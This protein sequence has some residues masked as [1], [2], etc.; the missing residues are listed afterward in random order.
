[1]S[2]I[3]GLPREALDRARRSRDPRFDGKFFVAVLSTGIY[4]RSTCPVRLS[5]AIRYYATAAAA[6][7]AGFRPCL[8]C[9][10]EAAPGSPAWAGTSAVVR[11]ALR[12]IQ[13]GALDTGSVEELAAHVGLGVRHLSRLM[14]GQVGASPLAIAQTRR[15]H[16][17]KQLLNDT[18]IPMTEIA[19]AAGFRSVRRFNEAVKAAYK[20]SPSEIRRRPRTRSGDASEEITLQLSY[21]PPYDW[22]HM[23]TF[24]ARRAIPS[25]ERVDAQSYARTVRT[26]TGHARIEI[27]PC[28]KEHA[29]EMR[30]RGAAPADLFEL[31]SAA[32]RVFD[33]SADPH[34]IASAF[35]DDSILSTL[36]AQRPGLRI[37]GVFDPFECAVRAILSQ[38][39]SID[40]GRDFTARLVARAGQS[41]DPA[42][43]GL[44]RLFPTPEIIADLDLGNVGLSTARIAAIRALARAMCDGAIRFNASAEDIIRALTQLPGVGA[45]T[46]QYVALHGL[47]DPDAFLATDLVLRRAVA[48]RATP[49]TARALKER[50]EPW[51]PWRGYAVMHLW[52]AAPDGADGRSP[53]RRAS[54]GA[55][56]RAALPSAS[57]LRTVDDGA[58]WETLVPLQRTGALQRR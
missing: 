36:V 6:A 2:D 20:R 12:L 11:R 53:M 5:T 19:L 44:T 30:V 51:R 43:D 58:A 31:T 8:R 15:L 29:V 7:E 23:L 40:V 34:Q 39:V 47:G 37:P 41:I 32:R 25:L 54:E 33:L 10:P 3:L 45:W 22:S 1:M 24:L 28:Q 13:D 35:G 38:Q 56:R 55:P 50:A 49:S 48:I 26:S 52:A 57:L 18:D 16:F 14:L 27:R 46:A 4:C 9:R 17:A 42:A 21:R